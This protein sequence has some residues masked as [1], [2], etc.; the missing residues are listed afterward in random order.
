MPIPGAESRLF[1][2]G[3]LNLQVAIRTAVCVYGSWSRGEPA[4]FDRSIVS[5]IFGWNSYLL[6]RDSHDSKQWIRREERVVSDLS[7]STATSS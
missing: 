6:E 2:W 1:V 4:I 3:A 5:E 7:V